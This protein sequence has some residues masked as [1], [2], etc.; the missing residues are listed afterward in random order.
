MV[1]ILPLVFIILA[2]H[3]N[4]L[5]Q[6]LSKVWAHEAVNDEVDGGVEH[7]QVPD[8]AVQQPPHG[9][10]VVGTLAVIALKKCRDRW[11]FIKWHKHPWNIED[12][13]DKYNSDHYL[14]HGHFK[15]HSREGGKSL[16]GNF[17]NFVIEDGE[18][19][20][21]EYACGEE[22][23]ENLIDDAS[24]DKIFLLICR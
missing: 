11:H 6:I 8:D 14:G 20:D 18:N 3:W 17:E 4:K 23:M 15:C 1:I 19:N 21:G 16:F 5:V 10:D 13:E 12:D 22:G 9:G 24:L 2:L 7:D